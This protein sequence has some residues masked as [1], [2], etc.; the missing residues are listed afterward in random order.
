MFNDVC[1]QVK[2]YAADQLDA[3]LEGAKVIVIPAGVPRK[4]RIQTVTLIAWLLTIFT[5]WCKSAMLRHEI[6]PH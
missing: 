3:A 2:G 1:V 6:S 4:V 5:A